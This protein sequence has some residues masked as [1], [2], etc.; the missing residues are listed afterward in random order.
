MRKNVRENLVDVVAIEKNMLSGMKTLRKKATRGLS[1]LTLL[2]LNQ[3]DSDNNDNS[4][5][6]NDTCFLY[7]EHGESKEKRIATNNDAFFVNVTNSG[8]FA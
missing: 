4:D 3:E 6:H 8:E 5:R 1:V 2:S 7:S